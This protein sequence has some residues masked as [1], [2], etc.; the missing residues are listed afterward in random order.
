MYPLRRQ[1]IAFRILFVAIFRPKK[2]QSSEETILILRQELQKC[3]GVVKE[4]RV[5][6]STLRTEVD[7]KRQDELRLTTELTLLKERLEKCQVCDFSSILSKMCFF[8]VC[9]PPM[10]GG[11]FSPV[12]RFL[13]SSVEPQR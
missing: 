7:Q 3:L 10:T 6:L 9:V 4:K 11:G 5:E 8:K 13:Y 12:I 1:E 2:E